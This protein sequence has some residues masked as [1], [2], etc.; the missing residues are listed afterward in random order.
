[1]LFLL[2]ERGPMPHMLWIGTSVGPAG[3]VLDY[4]K[5]GI[6]GPAAIFIKSQGNLR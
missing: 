6:N 5:N 1:M 4:S 3:K 2:V